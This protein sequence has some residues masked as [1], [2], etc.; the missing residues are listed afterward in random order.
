MVGPLRVELSTNGLWVRCSNQHE[1][2]SHTAIVA[3]FLFSVK[4]LQTFSAGTLWLQNQIPWPVLVGTCCNCP[5]V[6]CPWHLPSWDWV[7]T[8]CPHAC[9]CYVDTP[10]SLQVPG[11]DQTG[12]SVGSK[13]L[14]WHLPFLLVQGM[15]VNAETILP[16][17]DW[18]VTAVYSTPL[19]PG[20]DVES[21]PKAG[22]SRWQVL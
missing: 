10:H 22:H 13:L 5:N 20:M 16:G 7:W 2:R 9:C 1:L 15:A 17:P 4:L 21:T 8:Q 19:G 14:S 6:Q 18:T 11:V 3:G 12:L